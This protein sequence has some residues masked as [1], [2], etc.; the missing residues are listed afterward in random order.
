MSE[1]TLV[2]EGSNIQSDILKGLL[3]D[4]NI[5]VFIKNNSESARTAGFGHFGSTEVYIRQ[6]DLEGAREI[7]QE[8]KSKN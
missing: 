7:V 5:G 8:F 6:A 3:E 4:A 2:F 1:L